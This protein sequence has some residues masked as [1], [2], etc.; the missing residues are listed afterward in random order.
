V[1]WFCDESLGW[2]WESR[3]RRG[4]HPRMKAAS[5]RTWGVGRCSG[6]RAETRP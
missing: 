6:G 4:G 5:S 2:L 1:A 3:V